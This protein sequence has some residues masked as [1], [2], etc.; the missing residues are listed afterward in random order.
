MSDVIVC[1]FGEFLYFVVVITIF[2]FTSVQLFS[3]H[4]LESCLRRNP[5]LT[6]VKSL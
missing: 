3:S 2:H 4:R 1:V 5:G 6:R